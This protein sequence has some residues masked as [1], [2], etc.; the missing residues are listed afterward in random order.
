MGF[1]RVV[2]GAPIFPLGTA[3][4][5][6]QLPDQVRPLTGDAGDHKPWNANRPRAS[7]PT[8][9]EAK[10]LKGLH[11]FRH[12]SELL[13]GLVC[14]A[15]PLSMASGRKSPQKWPVHPES[16]LSVLQAVGVLTM[17]LSFSVWHHSEAREPGRCGAT[18]E[19]P[20]SQTQLS[21]ECSSTEISRST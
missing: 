8:P 10:S 2:P 7:W 14:G 17:L 11:C 15:Q 16:G 1:V 21:P 3:A 18:A 4:R 20:V 6:L 19:S 9:T 13:A 5:A 12:S